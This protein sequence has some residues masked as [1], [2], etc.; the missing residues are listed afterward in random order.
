MSVSEFED[1]DGEGKVEDS[2]FALISGK[3]KF[4]PA[5]QIF[6]GPHSEPFV[7]FLHEESPEIIV[8]NLGEFRFNTNDT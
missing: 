5:S 2:N 4:V 6:P 1:N 8:E 3:L 7:D